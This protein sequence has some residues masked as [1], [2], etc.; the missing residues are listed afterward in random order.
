[1]KLLAKI[2]II[3]AIFC[4]GFYA[5]QNSS[6]NPASVLSNNKLIESG[7]EIKVSLMLDFGDG[8]IQTFS[9][10]VLPDQANVFDLLTKVTT[11]KSLE[12]KTKDYGSELGVLVESINNIAN[13]DKTNR[14]WH[15]WVNNEYAEVG[16]SKYGLKTGDIV[17]WKY[18]QNQFNLI[19][20]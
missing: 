17:E 11:E 5:G 14:F 2:I 18:V 10:V 3:A 1:M 8:K 20:N 19:K 12:F 4:A 9:D 16:A 7:Q 6:F 13:S 15:Y